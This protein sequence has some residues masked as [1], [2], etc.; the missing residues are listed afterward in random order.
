[1]AVTFS[2]FSEIIIEYFEMSHYNIGMGISAILYF[3]QI[4]A[5][6]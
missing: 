6:R 4:K 3:R 1:M 2:Q 5:V